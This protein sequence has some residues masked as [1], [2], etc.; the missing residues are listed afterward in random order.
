MALE[1]VFVDGDVLERNQPLPRL[2]LGNTV[3]EQ[4]GKAVGETIR[5]R[6]QRFHLRASRYGGR[7]GG[8]VGGPGH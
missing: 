5:R 4:G 7:V 3:D 2:V 1:K 6:G 8:Q